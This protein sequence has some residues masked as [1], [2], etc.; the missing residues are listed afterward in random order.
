[1]VFSASTRTL[2]LLLA[3]TVAASAGSRVSILP[4]SRPAS[5]CDALFPTKVS[6]FSSGDIGNISVAVYSAEATDNTAADT[7]EGI[8]IVD[9]VSEDARVLQDAAGG[10]LGVVEPV[11]GCKSLLGVDLSHISEDTG[12]S[13]VS[14]CEKTHEGHL[15]CV[16]EGKLPASTQ[17]QVMLPVRTWTQRYMQ[18][19]CGGLCGMIRMG[20]NAASGSQHVRGGEFALAATDMGGGMDGKVFASNP[21]RRKSFAYSAQHLTSLVS[22]TLMQAYYG[23]KPRYSYFNGCSD[24]G[25]EGV[26]EALRYPND[27]DGIL[28]GAP[29]MLFQFQNSLH[30]G[31]SGAA[32]FA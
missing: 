10:H 31:W 24:G 3:L 17:W 7:S 12:A 32:W 15:Y 22:K 29:A 25:R 27:F 16:V 28:A 2:A 23:Q 30:H 4:L 18:V 21:G 5:T 8:S 1:M 6:T 20:V 11:S 26:M 13:V 19:G 14:A 9:S